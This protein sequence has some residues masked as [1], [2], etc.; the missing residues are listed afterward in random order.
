MPKSLREQVWQRAR[1][2]CEYC[3]IPQECDI[4]PF[5]LDHIRAQKHGGPTVL[6]NLALSWLPCNSFKGSDVASYDPL[7]DTLVPLFNPRTQDWENHFQ[8]DGPEL[9][10]QTPTAR[11]TIALLRINAADRVAH[12]KILIESGLFPAQR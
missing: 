5:Q 1:G 2:C 11:A 6:R 10:G 12:R 4:R 8:W 9:S 7:T 3:G